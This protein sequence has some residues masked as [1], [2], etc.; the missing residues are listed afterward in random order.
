MNQGP[1]T[2]PGTSDSTKQ[3]LQTGS[4]SKPVGSRTEHSITLKSGKTS[5][6]AV[7]DWMILRKKEKPIAEMFY[8]HYSIA[9]NKAD[10]NRPVTFVFNGGPGA[11][12]AYLHMGALGPKRVMFAADGSL[13]PPPTRLTVHSTPPHSASDS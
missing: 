12:S 2:A 6:A 13:L 5:Y 7:A 8:V 11:S 9:K 10:K 1:I 4:T 3:T